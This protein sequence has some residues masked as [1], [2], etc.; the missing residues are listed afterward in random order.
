MSLPATTCNTSTPLV[1]SIDHHWKQPG[2]TFSFH[3]EKLEEG[4]Q[5]VKGLIPILI[6]KLGAEDKIRSFF[7]PCAF[8]EGKDLLFDPITGA[9]SSIANRDLASI[10]DDY[11]EMSAIQGHSAPVAN[12]GT[13]IFGQRMGA[14]LS[15]PTT[16]TSPL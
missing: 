6:H 14:A 3:P 13:Q 10:F 7:T 1:F 15:G 9:V 11:D 16:T 12:S 2:H 8:Q 5:T 4:R